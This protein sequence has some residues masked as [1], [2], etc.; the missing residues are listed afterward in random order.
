MGDPAIVRS[1]AGRGAARD[2]RAAAQRM[3]ASRSWLACEVL[4][5]MPF[6][7]TR[8]LAFVRV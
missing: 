8:W 7:R 6:L 5:K 3:F 1:R 2:T 4:S